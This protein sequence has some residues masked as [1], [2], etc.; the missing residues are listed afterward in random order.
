MNNKKSMDLME[1]SLV[2]LHSEIP[3]FP[4]KTSL[5]ELDIFRKIE[6]EMHESA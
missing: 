3:D 4:N 1:E 6:P 2:G 5:I